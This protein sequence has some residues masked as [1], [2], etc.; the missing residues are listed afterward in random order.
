[1]QYTILTNKRGVKKMIQYGNYR[2]VE[3]KE[4]LFNS[5]EKI[6]WE[7]ENQTSF[8]SYGVVEHR[9]DKEHYPQYYKYVKTPDGR[10]FCRTWCKCEKSEIKKFFKGILE[11]KKNEIKLLEKAIDKI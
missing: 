7:E 10:D 2:I 3:K 5:R 9:G 4:D 8:V 6:L 1:M 11:E